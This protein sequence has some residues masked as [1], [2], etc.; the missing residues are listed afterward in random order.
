MNDN[1]KR[2]DEALDALIAAAYRQGESDCPD[3]QELQKH[4]KFLTEDDRTALNELPSDFVRQ[5]IG[6]TWQ[7]K[8]RDDGASVEDE[9]L[10]TAMNRADEDVEITDAAKDEMDRKLAEFEESEEEDQE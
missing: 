4:A 8:E 9:E 7:P 10:L 2:E 3:L 5:V 1:S 6:K